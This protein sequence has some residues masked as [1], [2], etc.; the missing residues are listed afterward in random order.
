MDIDY[1]KNN[2]SNVKVHNIEGDMHNRCFLTALLEG[3]KP[4]KDIIILTGHLDVVDIDEFGILKNIAFDYKEY[5]KRVSDLV[6][7][8]DSKRI[9]ILM[10][11]YLVEAQQI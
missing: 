8:Q 10:S 6:L 11:G 1:F 3:K 7:D 5:T 4:S 9:Y 2:K